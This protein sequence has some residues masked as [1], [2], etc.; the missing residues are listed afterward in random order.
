M[1]NHSTYKQRRD[2]IIGKIMDFASSLGEAGAAPKEAAQKLDELFLEVVG[3]D[4]V[5]LSHV[6]TI[7]PQ[8]HNEVKASI[9]QVITGETK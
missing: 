9:R 8:L 4:E 2:E 1:I 5:E 7:L 3:E 6:N